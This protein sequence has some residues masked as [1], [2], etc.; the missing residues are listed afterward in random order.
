MRSGCPVLHGGKPVGIISS[1]GYAPTLG[2]SIGMGYL[3]VE[4]AQQGTEVEVD[5]RGRPLPAVVVPRPFYRR[6]KG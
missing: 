6:A 2:V 5:V 3:P 1:G 4:L